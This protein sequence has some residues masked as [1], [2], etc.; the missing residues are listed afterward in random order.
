MQRALILLLI[1][2]LSV[3]SGCTTPQAHALGPDATPTY[4]SYFFPQM[5]WGT[6]AAAAGWQPTASSTPLPTQTLPPSPTETLPTDTPTPVLSR[7][8]AESPM[9]TYSAPVP[10]PTAPA[11]TSLAATVNVGLLSCRYGPGPEYLYLYALRKGANIKLVGRV[12]S[13]NWH[14]AWVEGRNRCW[15]NTS[16]LTV[17]GDWRQLPIVYPGLAKLPVSPYYPPTTIVSVVRNGTSVTVEWAPIFLRA[18]D[19]EDEYMKHYI[20][21]VWQC[22]GGTLLFEPRATNYTYLTLI[23][24]PGCAAPSHARL[25][26]Q[27]KH[28]FSGPTIV[29]WRPAQ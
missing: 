13:D 24:E 16:Y 23:D 3:S 2:A 21:E 25:F 20:L 12:D 17:Q 22:R 19:E 15:V 14:W 18:G 26:V 10:S 6:I 5:Y 9:A 4:Y 29:P 8:G 7:P 11:A 27:E 28:G 1:G